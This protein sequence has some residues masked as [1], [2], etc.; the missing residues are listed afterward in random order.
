M[1]FLTD[2]IQ[3]STNR[4]TLVVLQSSTAQSTLPVLLYLISQLVAKSQSTETILFSLLH[5]PKDLLPSTGSQDFEVHDWLD[6][7][8]DYGPSDGSPAGL[9]IL[10]CVEQA[11]SRTSFPIHVVV[12]SV[13]TLASDLGSNTAAYT[14]ISAV[15][16]RIVSRPGSTLILHGGDP[17]LVSLLVQ[18]SLAHS[19]LYIKGHPPTLV[20]YIA[21]EYLT[22]PP[23]FSPA[24]KFWSIFA[25]L[26]ERQHTINELVFGTDE[27]IQ[28]DTKEIL[29]ETLIR[30]TGRKRSVEK[31]LEAWSTVAGSCTWTQLES[32]RSVWSKQSSLE[33]APAV[34]P[35]QNLSFNLGMTT[36]QQEARAQVPLPYV[37]DEN[38]PEK[39][40]LSA[41]QGVILYDPD[42]ADDIDDDDPDEDLDI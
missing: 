10:F 40:R 41:N 4:P 33:P 27:Q 2:F 31:E 6:H 35:T 24:A 18:P 8:P 20:S 13:D 34:D 26:S 38:Q 15:H 11:L 9:G 29:L 12:D 36:A 5:P 37:H 25:P 30:T 23:P 22:P 39:P 21:T 14:H 32:L 28:R 16:S 3:G 19:L 42:S 1:T 7:V 17:S